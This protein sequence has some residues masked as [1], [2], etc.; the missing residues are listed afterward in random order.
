MIESIAGKSPPWLAKFLRG[1][2]PFVT[3]IFSI[4]S[5]VGPVL[6]KFYGFLYEVELRAFQPI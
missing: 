3:V 1:S 5:V 6:L 4:L 2:T